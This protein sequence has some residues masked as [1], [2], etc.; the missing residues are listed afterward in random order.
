M[1]ELQP[2]VDD[3]PDD[4]KAALAVLS[5]YIDP[6][7]LIDGDVDGEKHQVPENRSS[8]KKMWIIVRKDIGMH[9][10]KGFP[11]VGH[12]FLNSWIRGL[13]INPVVALA[14]ITD[15]QPKIS[16]GVKSESELLKAYRL[17]QEAALP[18]VII[19]DA[20]RTFFLEPTYTVVCVG[21]CLMQELPRFVSSLRLLK[22]DKPPEYISV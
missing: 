18:C 12:G 13:F 6:S 7:I 21:P 16:V 22:T 5:R 1:T 2:P 14:Y 10:E 3:T 19:K 9:V 11:Q 8:E 4:L 17:C 20:A 15:A